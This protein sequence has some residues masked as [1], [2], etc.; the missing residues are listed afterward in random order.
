[1]NKLKE[2]LKITGKHL[3]IVEDNINWLLRELFPDKT[4]ILLGEF[5][6]VYQLVGTGT[7]EE[8]QTRIISSIRARGGLTKTYFEGLFNTLGYG[9]YTVSIAEGTD[10]IGLRVHQYSRLTSPQG[11][12]SI[13]D[14][15]TSLVSSPPYA[16]TPYCI[17]TTVTGVAGPEAELE[18]L[19]NRLKPAWT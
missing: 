13:I 2:A 17:T 4:T 16:D 12:A 1:M 9:R 15:T 6:R 11:P 18:T 10:N 3:D 8:R 19:F 5:E 7:I 14:G